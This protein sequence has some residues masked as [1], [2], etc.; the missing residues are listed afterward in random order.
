M[1]K[2]MSW[3]FPFF[4]RPTPSK[5]TESNFPFRFPTF[6]CQV[7]EALSQ[8]LAGRYVLFRVPPGFELWVTSVWGSIDPSDGRDNYSVYVL[9]ENSLL[10]AQELFFQHAA[11]I[12]PDSFSHSFVWPVYVSENRGVGM[13][14]SGNVTGCLTGFTGWVGP[15]VGGS[16]IA[17]R[18]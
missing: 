15:K 4:R 14:L 18:F 7:V 16:S 9:Q 2:V 13:Y 8:P 17:T 12:T 5:G 11:A 10:S 3:L 6:S 1:V